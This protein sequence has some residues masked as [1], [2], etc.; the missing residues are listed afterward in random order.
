[1]F[2]KYLIVFLLSSV[3]FALSFPLAIYEYKF[4]YIETLILTTS[5]GIFGSFIF[6]YLTKYIVI[7][8]R[9][10]LDITKLN[11]INYFNRNKNIPRK[12]MTR[13][14]K[15]IVIVRTKYGLIGL[16]L[17][18]PILL[19]IPIGTFISLRYYPNYKKTLLYLIISIV[20]WANII[21]LVLL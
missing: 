12:K 6:A 20:M 3:K 13:R 5:G 8:W 1:M 11:N 9:Y 17:I 7:I 19:S 21:S 18:T 4:S 10:F 15:L 16:A 2:V 14:N